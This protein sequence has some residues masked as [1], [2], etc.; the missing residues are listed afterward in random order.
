MAFFGLFGS[1]PVK[2]L[3]RAE[4]RLARGDGLGARELAEPLLRGPDPAH[5][6]R[7]RE[8]LAA[9]RDALYA[10]T[11][12]K[13]DEAEAEGRFADAADWLDS[14]LQH[15]ADED[16]PALEARRGSLLDRAAEDR[17]EV[18]GGGGGGGG[19]DQGGDDAA[20]DAGFEDPGLDHEATFATLIET[21]RDDV[22]GEYGGRPEP[23]PA[24]WV[25]LNEGRGEEAQPA[26]D[27]LVEA[28][29]ADPVYRLERGRARLLLGDAAGARED[30]EAAW[31]HW[32]DEPLD[33]A[34]A[35]SVPVLWAQALLDLGEPEPIL[36]RLAER[37]DPA[38]GDAEL[39]QLYG[40][41]LLGAGRSEEA[42]TFLARAAGWFPTDPTLPFLLAG[43]LDQVDRRRD[44]IDCLETAIAPSCAGGGC[45]GPPLHTPSVHL[46]V[47][48]YLKRAGE[49]ESGESAAA[50]SALARAGDLVN[51]IG[52]HQGDRFSPADHRLAARWY[53]Q[54]GHLESARRAEA[55]ADR[56]EAARAGGAAGLEA[57]AS[58]PVLL[59]GTGRAVL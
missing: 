57:V 59:P 10:S 8:I 27:A 39:S 12:A 41:A 1:D 18:G 35:V 16:R 48:L 29:P 7:A 31:E 32:G 23:F 40:R 50:R 24:A 3:D 30:L 15:A 13:A 22:A 19:G 49:Q 47:E 25:A 26:L 43:A 56:L 58:P 55:E 45:G 4:A 9:A 51:L 2:T 37:A 21:L 38:R 6:E 46:L 11:R 17:F 36:D 14:A 42:R 20:D 33:R 53:A 44:A 28:D 52:L 5:R 54:A 34:G